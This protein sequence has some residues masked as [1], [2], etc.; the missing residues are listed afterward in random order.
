MKIILL[1]IG[2]IVITIFIIGLIASGST[3]AAPYD[4]VQ[5]QDISYQGCKRVTYKITVP[6]DSSEQ[7]IELTMKKIIDDSKNQ[8]QDITVWAYKD[9]EKDIAVN[10]PYTKGMKE[11]SECK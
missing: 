10:S 8:W 5:K 2:G 3:S 7:E 6:N 11:Y 9:S 1:I 4:V